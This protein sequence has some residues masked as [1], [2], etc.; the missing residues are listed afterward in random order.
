MAQWRPLY[1]LVTGT[2]TRL[3][4][5]LSNTALRDSVPFRLADRLPRFLRVF[6][7]F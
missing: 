5:L 2:A 7:F 3:F 1:S 4:S 6:M